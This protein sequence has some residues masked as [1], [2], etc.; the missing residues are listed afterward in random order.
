MFVVATDSLQSV[1]VDNVPFPPHLHGWMFSVCLGF[2]D[3][4]PATLG[5]SLSDS[6]PDR[7][8]RNLLI[9]DIRQVRAEPDLMSGAIEPESVSS[10]RSAPAAV[11]QPKISWNNWLTK[12]LCVVQEGFM[13][14]TSTIIMSAEATVH[15]C[16]VTVE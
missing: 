12:K 6:M 4:Q 11:S 14:V 16:S 5:E 3:A 2:E 9:Q 8:R 13:E 10:W 1:R 15:G 7:K